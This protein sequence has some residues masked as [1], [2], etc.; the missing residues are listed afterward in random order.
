M[1]PGAAQLER[2]R[3][4]LRAAIAR[5]RRAVADGPRRRRRRWLLLL[6]LLLLL[7]LLRPCDA[8]PPPPGIAGPPAPEAVAPAAG[9]PAAEPPVQRVP[10]RGRPPFQS[11][12]PEPLPWLASFRLQVAARSTR[13][14][15]CFVGVDRPGALKWTVAVEPR[16]GRVSDPTLEPTLSAE[17]LTPAQRACALAVLSEPTY[18]LDAGEA[19]STPSRVGMVIEF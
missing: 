17:T 9:P 13:L 4:E 3:Q 15:A 8:E 18:R 14:A 6:P 5:R 1:R 2:R 7:L 12:A 11:A 16:T 19:P 10:R